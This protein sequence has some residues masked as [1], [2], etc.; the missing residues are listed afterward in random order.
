MSKEMFIAA[1]EALIEEYLEKHPNATEA[2]AYDRTADHA[3]DRM[4]D[5]LAD[6]IDYLRMRRKDEQLEGGKQ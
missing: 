6:R 5:N 4:R 2:E 3:Y 1:H